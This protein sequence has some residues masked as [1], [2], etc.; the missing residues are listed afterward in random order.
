MRPA[1]SRNDSVICTGPWR[2]PSKATRRPSSTSGTTS[3]PTSAIWLGKWLPPP[4]WAAGS[5]RS[6]GSAGRTRGAGSLSSVLRH[7]MAPLLCR[8]AVSWW[9]TRARWSSPARR[10]LTDWARGV[11]DAQIAA[12]SRCTKSVWPWA[13]VAGARRASLARIARAI[14]GT[15]RV[16][17]GRYGGT[18]HTGGGSR[19]QSASTWR[20]RG[21]GRLTPRS[22]TME[23][24]REMSEA[25]REGRGVHRPG[26]RPERSKPAA[27]ALV[28][29]EI[30]DVDLDPLG[31]DFPPLRGLAVIGGVRTA[32]DGRSRSRSRAR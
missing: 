4:D 17:R 8:R 9:A 25:K 23:G 24:G 30:M 15:H 11:A 27:H 22:D 32:E 16:E 12:W 29:A 21:G 6:I 14:T 19:Q 26:F 3:A 10:P 28:I 20:E 18:G 7:V 31:A 5:Q 1:G 13:D 2:P